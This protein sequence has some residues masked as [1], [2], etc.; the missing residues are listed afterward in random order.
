MPRP[1]RKEIMDGSLRKYL[2]TS[3]EAEKEPFMEL[4]EPTLEEIKK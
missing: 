2:Q 4:G 3:E 1:R